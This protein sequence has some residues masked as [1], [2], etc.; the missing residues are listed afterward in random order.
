[1]KSRFAKLTPAART[2]PDRPGLQ[3][4][5]GSLVKPQTFYL[6]ELMTD[7]RAHEL[8]FNLVSPTLH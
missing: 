8:Q 3:N 7:Y 6:A 4:R 1:M 5:R 2:D